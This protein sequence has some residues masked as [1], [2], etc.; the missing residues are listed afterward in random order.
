[1]Y[2][3]LEEAGLDTDAFI[4]FLLTGASDEVTEYGWDGTITGNEWTS[5]DG[6]VTITRESGKNITAWDPY[7]YYYW[8]VED[9]EDWTI[10]CN[11]DEY[12]LSEISLNALDLLFTVNGGEQLN[13][14]WYWIDGTASVS[15]KTATVHIDEV[16]DMED[17]TAYFKVTLADKRDPWNLA[18]VDRTISDIYE[19]LHQYAGG[20][21]YGFD[22]NFTAHIKDPNLTEGGSAWE[23]TWGGILS[24][25]SLTDSE[26]S[27][28][29]PYFDANTWNESGT[30]EVDAHQT[31][32]LP[33]GRYMLTAAGR[34]SQNNKVEK[35]GTHAGHDFTNYVWEGPFTEPGAQDPANYFQLY[36]TTFEG[37][38]VAKSFLE[39]EGNKGGIF[40]N[41]WNDA[42]VF[43]TM[44]SVGDVTIGVR[45]AT[46][47]KERWAS[48]TRF[49]LTRL[50]DATVY[51]NEDETLTDELN[52][53]VV[54]NEIGAF[55]PTDFLLKKK[56]EAGKW[57][58]FAVPIDISTEQLVANFGEDV[59]LAIPV[60]TV[61]EE[62]QV[63]VNFLRY[64]PTEYY[65]ETDIFENPIL[66]TQAN[67]PYLIKPA[68]VKESNR[69][70][71]K[72]ITT[73]ETK[74]FF[75]DGYW[76]YGSYSLSLDEDNWWY[77]LGDE[78]DVKVY[79]NY[80]FQADVPEAYTIEYSDTVKA[81]TSVIEAPGYE[82]AGVGLYIINDEGYVVPDDT[83]LDILYQQL[84]E[85]EALGAQKA[86]WYPGIPAAITKNMTN[87]GRIT[88]IWNAGAAL[89]RM[90]NAMAEAKKAYEPSKTF[91]ALMAQ[92][93]DLLATEHTE[94]VEGADDAFKSKL[95]DLQKRFDA[96]T[97]AAP[98]ADLIDELKAAI[99][100]YKEQIFI[101]GV[102]EA[103]NYYIKNVATGKYLN[104]GNS[105][106]TRASVSDNL[107][108]F[109]LAALENGAYTLESRYNNGGEQFYLGPNY[110]V[111]NGTPMELTIT[112]VGE[113]VWTI[114]CT[115]ESG[116]GY[117][118]W[119]GS[120]S[121]EA[122]V[123]TSASAEGALWTF[124]SEADMLATLNDASL[125]NP[126]NATILIK[127]PNFSRNHR[128]V[129]AWDFQYTGNPSGSNCR[130]GATSDNAGNYNTC[131]EAWQASFTLTQALELPNGVYML[132]AQGAVT[133]YAQTGAD[134]PVFFAGDET[135]VFAEMDEVDRGSNMYQLTQRF[136]KGDYT[137]DPI[138][139]EV[140]D[141]TLS[142]GARGVRDDIW[143]IWDN[144]QLTYFGNADIDAVRAA[145]PKN[146]GATTGINEVN[147]G[148]NTGAIYNL[149]G[150]RMNNMTK[151][152]IYIVNGKKIVVK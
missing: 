59:E 61:V 29:Y 141:G 151:K 126:V 129:S 21:Y 110:F 58:S 52:W 80:R 145:Y 75:K 81:Y 148:V 111:D 82:I 54:G 34:A 44:P 23:S 85:A 135:A 147:T 56:M 114:A 140:D 53:D 83:Y 125:E 131:A 40:D 122:R 17:P 14:F 36:A 115:G 13:S 18:G 25:E 150:V 88:N 63:V 48:A 73:T 6:L 33:P 121:T 38:T 71:F 3:A 64:K 5:T 92:A 91:N 50:G 105:W 94:L 57:Y 146:T 144:F 76:S 24:S 87:F 72:N 78:D 77:T 152:G 62:E 93:N 30:M 117:L 127:D 107:D 108:Y 100:A 120:E 97:E 136:D 132:T 1:M 16:L 55:A 22:A 109:T 41:G 49:R 67:L 133:D 104:G 118:G 27:N 66:G 149:N 116:F 134:F 4:G 45:A 11:S 95:A 15:G 70:L 98:I 7:Y 39:L 51:L 137:C 42:S 89:K 60:E 130:L 79:P 9:G 84:D 112:A 128:D 74:S 32:Q 43:F 69:Y 20:Y 46:N 99:A 68:Q 124:I 12:E 10:T 86:E 47:V 19:M 103:G 28:E 35:K 65:I 2:T 8:D 90:K 102:L 96:L 31:I 113:N 26:G 143:T 139:V 119:D 138:I 37:K 106:G 142:I 123:L 101:A